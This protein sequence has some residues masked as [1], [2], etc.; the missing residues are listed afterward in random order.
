VILHVLT[1]PDRRGGQL[2]AAQLRDAFAARG[3]EAR[4]V[5]LGPGGGGGSLSVTV[6]GPARMSAR[7]LR[8][9]RSEIRSASVVIGFGSTTLPACSIAGLGLDTPFIYRSIGDIRYWTNSVARR[10][11]VRYFLRR[12]DAVV[13]LW[14]AA[15]EALH[16]VF[17]VPSERIRVIPNA[18][19]A[20]SFPP[21][22]EARRRAARERLGV[23]PE[24]PLLAWIGALA[25]EKNA[26]LAIEAVGLVE[27]CHLV[28]VGDGPEL[29][30][31]ARV[32]ERRA[33]DRIRFTGL[34][35]DPATVLAAADAVLL[36]SRSE[37]MPGVL[38][39]AGLSGLPTVATDVGGVRE[40]VLPG[41]T[42]ELVP[43]SASPQD[44][45]VAIRSVL[46]RRSELGVAARELCR[47]RF[48]MEVVADAWLHLID[49]VTARRAPG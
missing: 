30:R 15:A 17:G 29:A 24:V 3:R 47:R 6:L 49:E 4:A 9:L 20:A 33:D 23:E 48:E 18:V 39:E 8:S 1:D 34:V 5:A 40:I 25:R 35:Q 22:D 14:P 11:R 21:V 16:E 2:F 41:E 42:G 45:A 46:G 13:A 31:V 44:V 28:I 10:A 27:S 32:A 26:D 19:P 36:T 12:A 37:G 7:T 38:I 43:P